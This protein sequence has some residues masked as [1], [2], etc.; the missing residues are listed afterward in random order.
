MRR[1]RLL[2]GEPIY[3]VS[4]PIKPGPSW[5]ENGSGRNGS[6]DADDIIPRPTEPRTPAAL[7]RVKTTGYHGCWSGGWCCK[8]FTGAEMKLW[9]TQRE[10]CSFCFIYCDKSHNRQRTVSH[11]G[12][13]ERSPGEGSLVVHLC[14][15]YRWADAAATETSHAVALLLPFILFHLQTSDLQGPNNRMQ[16]VQK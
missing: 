3:D 15:Y 9:K 14:F 8:T 11:C 10:C 1:V 2:N 16:L 12:M 6:C 4:I 7:T 5:E 13:V